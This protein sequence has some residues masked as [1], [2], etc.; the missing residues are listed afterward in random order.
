MLKN[1][2]STA[3]LVLL[4]MCGIMLCSPVPGEA[5]QG[6][7]L[8][9]VYSFTGSNFGSA[10]RYDGATPLRGNLL[11]SNQRIYGVTYGGGENDMGVI[12]QLPAT[13]A[14]QE[15]PALTLHSFTT[16][17]GHPNGSLV[18]DSQGN[19]YGTTIT[20][21]AAN[22]GTVFKLTPAGTY[23]IL[24]AF[25]GP[26][27]ANPAAGVTL[28]PDGTLYGTAQKGGASSPPAIVE[29]SIGCGTVFK[30]TQSGTF[31]VIHSF[32]ISERAAG[33]ATN[34]V[35]DPQGNVI[36]T[37]STGLAANDGGQLFVISPAGKYST[38]VI[39]V[40][41]HAGVPVGNIVRDDAGNIYGMVFN[42]NQNVYGQG[43]HGSG[44]FKVTAVTHQLV[45][46]KVLEGQESY[47]GV[48][49][50]KAGNLYGTTTGVQNNGGLGGTTAGSVFA[51]A[52]SGTL[53]ALAALSL[54]NIAPLGGVIPDPSGILW[55]TTSA[56]GVYGG[57]PTAT[58][59]TPTACGTVFSLSP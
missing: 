9:T 54:D 31:Q 15:P 47:S 56:G 17:E 28:G 50:D 12:F 59:V 52:P 1:F 30:I 10:S 13:A 26:D 22:L 20:G 32:G 49:R 25:A 2:K 55:G 48:V 7:T 24:H 23:T 42:A 38:V 46:L 21:G 45:L 35:V 39:F 44:I 3:T 51:L 43:P 37:T 53:T 4:T 58:N 11:Y 41:P 40:G 33:P 27:G 14:H 57:C 19:L 36:G 6:L 18:A 29:C 34:V 16:Q 5:A 8:T